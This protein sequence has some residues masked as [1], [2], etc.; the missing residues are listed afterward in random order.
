MTSTPP[1]TMAL[2][3]ERLHLR[4]PVE[5]DADA[6]IAIAGDWG[7]ARRLARVP[8]PYTDAGLRFFFNHVVPSEPTWA[9]LWRQTGRLIGMIGLTPAPDGRCAE[10]G[11]YIACD[12]WG[13]GIA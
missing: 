11:Y 12:H 2:D 1:A 13:R 6:I 5:Q 8:H 7:V 3:T 9:I 4:R 10:L